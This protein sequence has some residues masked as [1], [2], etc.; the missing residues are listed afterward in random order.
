M[1][2]DN[3]VGVEISQLACRY[4]LF[5]RK[6]VSN[7]CEAVD[8]YKDSIIALTGLWKPSNEVH[9]NIVPFPLRNLQRLE[10]ASWF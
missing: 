1:K 7:L 3:L 5:D 9:L 6:E 8:H 10:N 4:C 2:T